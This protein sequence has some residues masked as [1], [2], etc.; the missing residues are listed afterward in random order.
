MQAKQTDTNRTPLLLGVL[1]VFAAIVKVGLQAWGLN[2]GY[3]VTDEGLYILMLN[4]SDQYP[5]EPHNYYTYIINAFLPFKSYGLLLLRWIGLFSELIAIS[6]FATSVLYWLKRVPKITFRSTIEPYLVVVLSIIYVAFVSVYP[7]AF[8]YN[9][10]S[11]LNTMLVAGTTLRLFADQEAHTQLKRPLVLALLFLLGGILG[12]QVIVKFSTSLLL[13]FWVPTYIFIRYNKDIRSAVISFAVLFAGLFTFLAFFFKGIDGFTT[14]YH[15]LE[16]GVKLLKQLSYDPYGVL[17]QG[18]LQVDVIEN[19]QYWLVPLL[20]SF[21]LK[22]ILRRRTALSKS[23][24]LFISYLTGLAVWLALSLLVH[25]Y[26]LGEFYYRFI[27]VHIFSLLFFVIPMSIDSYKQKQLTS[28][29]Y[30]VLVMALPVIS[31]MGSNNPMTQTLTRY[32]APWAVLTIILLFNAIPNIKV[33]SLA[34]GTL[35]VV[36]IAN[37]VTVQWYNPFAL[38]TTLAE[39]NEALKDHH[40]LNGIYVD[41]PTAKMFDQLSLIAKQSGYQVGGPVLALGDICGI[42]TAIG[43]YIP[44]TFWYFS[45]ESAT[46]P[47]HSRNYSCLHLNN[48]QIS[49]HPALPLLIISES[50]HQ[51]VLDCVADSQIPYPEQYHEVGEVYSPYRDEKLYIWAPDNWQPER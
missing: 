27:A 31:L 46:S 51:Q 5:T 36:S 19:A 9:D 2:R 13:L 39:Q 4:F 48:L 24:T 30:L 25:Q 32:L 21:A 47:Q 3:D 1:L 44:E 10:L 34:L 14:W 42:A 17:I 29:F 22:W 7:R 37:Y 41:H 26:F 35:V 23:T 33:R 12:E 16:E 15:N 18:Y 28:V 49:D 11:Y 38:P 43:G 50:T 8:S 40:Y 45:D 20:V 6:Y